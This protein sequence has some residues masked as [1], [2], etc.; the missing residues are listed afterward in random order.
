MEV[1]NTTDMLET[2]M[3]PF[4]LKAL[5]VSVLISVICA[6]SGIFVV[7][8]KM[9]FFSE[10]VSHSSLAGI[11]FALWFGFDPSVFLVFFS[12]VVAIAIALVS[13]S[14][15]SSRDSVI[16]IIHAATMSIGI[17]VLSFLHGGNT[18]ISRYL[19][20]DV[21]AITNTDVYISSALFIMA[22]VYLL[23]F[24]KTH[25]LT[26][27]T[28]DFARLSGISVK[29]Y[30]F[31]LMIALALVISASVK[32]AGA[33]LVT[34]LLIIPP[35]AAKNF[36]RSFSAFRAFSIIIGFTGAITGMLASVYF[37]L[38]AGPS[39]IIVNSAIYLISLFARR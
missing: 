9:A 14:S 16:G 13:Q 28:P 18:D 3:M 5:L 20:G 4:M 29:K 24:G 11:A 8:N 19:F 32:V 12:V 31:M 1:A 36:A 23:I 7:L 33:I 6:W 39:I 21:L 22:A 10:S 34:A 15:I 30:D 26:C 17:I 27:I 37:D 35:N 25:V 2:L 38:P